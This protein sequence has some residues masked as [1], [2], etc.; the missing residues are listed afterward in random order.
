VLEEFQIQSQA[1]SIS[2]RRPQIA[3]AG[4]GPTTAADTGMITGE[5][6]EFFVRFLTQAE[7]F[8]SRSLRNSRILLA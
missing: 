6:P 1:I 3:S 8:F 5:M 4:E 7:P 2:S